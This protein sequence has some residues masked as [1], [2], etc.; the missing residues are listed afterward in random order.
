ML[1]IHKNGNAIHVDMDIPGAQEQELLLVS[2]FLLWLI[3]KKGHK[4]GNQC[5]YND[6]QDKTMQLRYET[7]HFL[8]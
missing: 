1:G 2:S 4:L 3:E 7:L 5:S 8:L 6:C